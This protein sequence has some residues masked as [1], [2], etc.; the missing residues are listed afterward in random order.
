MNDSPTTKADCK[1]AAHTGG[2]AVSIWN[3]DVK[4]IQMLR[5]VYELLKNPRLKI[6][7]FAETKQ[8]K[9]IIW[10]IPDGQLKIT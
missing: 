3:D 7:K 8:I 2:E 6:V 1:Y 9:S 5:H 10:N 4:S